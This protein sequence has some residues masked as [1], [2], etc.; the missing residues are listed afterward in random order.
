[1]EGDEN[2]KGQVAPWFSLL[3]AHEYAKIH[4]KQT[5]TQNKVAYLA[6]FEGL[7]SYRAQLDKIIRD[8]SEIYNFNVT[9]SILNK[10][11]GLVMIEVMTNFVNFA[12]NEFQGNDIMEIKLSTLSEMY[13]WVSNFGEDFGLFFSPF[14]SELKELK[15]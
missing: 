12:H 10:E 3:E 7:C 4:I 11:N 5:C 6:I 14:I 1:M 9:H 2:K 13:Q 8:H 15:E